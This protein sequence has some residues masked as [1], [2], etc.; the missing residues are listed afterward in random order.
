MSNKLNLEIIK[1]IEKE[2]KKFFKG[3]SGCHD[4]SHVERVVNLAKKI[5]KKEKADVR[6]IEVAAYLHDIG[7]K[8]EMQKKG[9]FCHA[10]N[11]AVIAKEILKKYSL[12]EKIVD[13]ILHCIISHRFRNSH[14]PQTIEAKCL[15]D[16]DKLDSIGAIGI[17]R[18]CLFAGNAG[19]NTIYTGREKQLALQSKDYSYTCE[20]S[21]YLEYEVKLKHVKNKILTKTGKKIA[22]NR[23]QY[24]KEFFQRMWDEVEGKK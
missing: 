11:G 13:N 18:T 22:E 6:I 19:S 23:H 7:R 12:E 3:A 8:N 5:A 24:M 4:W 2:A 1:K 20:D 15:Y 16:A 14:V 10:E 9:K 21:A 17:T